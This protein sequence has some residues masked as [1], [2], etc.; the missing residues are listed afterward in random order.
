MIITNRFIVYRFVLYCVL[1]YVI[2]LVSETKSCE[3]SIADMEKA[4]V[5]SRDR[6]SV[7]EEKCKTFSEKVKSS[8][9][10]MVEAQSQ[11]SR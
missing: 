6:F 5:V 4:L 2:S 7:I 10:Q 8:R 3:E 1:L 11:K 9:S